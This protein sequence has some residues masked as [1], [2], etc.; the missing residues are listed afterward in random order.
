MNLMLFR[1]LASRLLLSKRKVKEEPPAVISAT[2]PTAI[3][4]ADSGNTYSLDSETA[5][6]VLPY[7]G[8][9][10]T[11]WT[12]KVQCTVVNKDIR[13]AGGDLGLG[14]IMMGSEQFDGL[15]LGSLGATV[16]L[17]FDGYF[18]ASISGTVTGYWD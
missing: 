7:S 12:I 15:I 5:R 6:I 17:E 9:L 8:T 4:A 2:E 1:G 3:T 11:G 18:L 14:V 10:T 16:L 13:C